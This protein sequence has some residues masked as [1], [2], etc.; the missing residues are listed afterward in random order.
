[1]SGALGRF[2][3]RDEARPFSV[4]DV[5]KRPIT[6]YIDVDLRHRN[7][8]MPFL[9]TSSVQGIMRV[10]RLYG[11][12]IEYAAPASDSCRDVWRGVCEL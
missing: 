9:D 6:G 2:P 5:V 7:P 4:P 1:M 3:A 11:K 10:A 12:F 8:S